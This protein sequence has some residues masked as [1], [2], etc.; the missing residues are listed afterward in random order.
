MTIDASIEDANQVEKNN[1]ER[2]RLLLEDRLSIELNKVKKTQSDINKLSWS[3][4][5]EMTLKTWGEKAHGNHLLHDRESL[6]WVKFSNYMHMV[7]ITMSAVSG[8]I[9]V[10]DTTFN[11][12]TYLISALT[13]SMG[14]LTSV[15]KY[16]K[17]DEKSL[18]H[19]TM[20]QKYS[21]IYRR[22]LIELGQMRSQRSHADEF[23]ERVKL[24]VDDLQAE[25]P[26]V[27]SAS[28]RYFL[29]NVKLDTKSF[30]DAV[31]CHTQPIEIVSNSSVE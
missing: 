25:A 6:N 28:I 10:S 16:Y 8:I 26:L 30:P 22:I 3:T 5:K 23:T 9:S 19:K 2:E 1:D 21:K 20:S 24:S 11:G 14:A 13:I 17:P 15:V 7:I 4:Q 12:T 31:N 18:L 29:R 27:S